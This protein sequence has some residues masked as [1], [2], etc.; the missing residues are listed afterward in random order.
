MD[1]VPAAASPPQE[2]RRRSQDRLVRFRARFK[3]KTSTTVEKASLITTQQPATVAVNIAAMTFTA[4]SSSSN[5]SSG[6]SPY[7]GAPAPI[8]GTVQ[9][10][11]FDNGGEGVAY[12]DTTYGNNGGQY[13][14]GD[15]DIEAASGGG[16]DVGW[17]AA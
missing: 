12:H 2:A 11:D 9:A 15:V 5:S 7:G 16:F 13:R 1:P 6:L 14:G 4:A 17:I 3:P 10:E 8:P